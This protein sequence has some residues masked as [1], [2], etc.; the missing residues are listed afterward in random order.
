[1]IKLDQPTTIRQGE[2][3]DRQALAA[4][5]AAQLPDIQGTLQIA[6]FPSGY[7]NLTYALQIG[8]TQLVLRRPPFGANIR[9]AHDMGRE[10]RVLSGLRRVTDKVPK[11]LLYCEDE[12]VLGAPFYVMERVRGLILRAKSMSMPQLTSQLTPLLMRQLSMAAIDMLA[13]IHGLDFVAAGLSELGRPEGYVERQI[14][15]WQR[16]YQ[17]VETEPLP[18][19]AEVTSW[20]EHHLPSEH[21]SALIHNDFKY[22]NLVLDPSDPTRIIAV[23]DWEMCTLGDPLMDLGTTLGYWIEATDP[24]ALID[25]FGLT[26]LPG[27]AHRG[28][29]VDRYIEKSGRAV[30]D[31]LFYYVYGLF[32]IAVIIQQIYFRYRQGTT[33]DPRFANLDQV[34]RDCTHLASLALE[35]DRIYHL[36]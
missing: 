33:Q 19:L 5:L 9:S 28:E 13:E 25:M 8:E 29:L 7:S 30:P 35:K 11:P 2:E 24:P 18:A 10:Y 31:P 36:T 23:L 22:D 1:M 34:V 17:N 12:A 4:Y 15:G 3:L 27:N 16:R 32:K 20:L 6:Q 21:A 14:R 26:A